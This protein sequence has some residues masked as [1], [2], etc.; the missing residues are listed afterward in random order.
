MSAAS[1]LRRGGHQLPTE[2]EQTPERALAVAVLNLAIEDLRHGRHHAR[3]WWECSP[4][5]ELWCEIIGVDGD[6][7]REKVLAG[8]AGK[9]GQ[10][11][12]PGKYRTRAKAEPEPE[13]PAEQ[14]EMAFGY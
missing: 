4:W 3:L 11:V 10:R 8:L 6:I 7:M 9:P 5:V 12:R 14:I 13:R 2:K 1:A